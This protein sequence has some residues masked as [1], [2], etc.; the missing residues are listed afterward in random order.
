MS[1]LYRGVGVCLASIAPITAVQF[2]AN[3]KFL[4]LL[5]PKY[6]TNA[7]TSDAVKI[8]SA[9]IAGA[10]SS[11][12]SSPAELVMTL[13]QN[14]GKSFVN[15]IQDVVKQHGVTRLYRGLEMTMA[16][17]SVW[18]ASYLALGPVITQR[19]HRISP[20]VFG[21]DNDATISQKASASAVGSILAGI[22]TVVATQPLDTVKTVMQGEALNVKGNNATFALGTA[23]RMYCQA[24][25][26]IQPFFRGIVPRGIRLV[27][28]VFILGRSREWFEE[29]F[30]EKQ[31]LHF[32]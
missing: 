22:A 32:V 18:C 4:A 6:N 19:M 25:H 9:S 31:I 30:E 5:Q 8:T 12:I 24:G 7:S 26:S 16:R 17:E 15:T 21:S 11:L 10:F 23:K 29:H 13:Q 3:G 20:S 28:A 27:G 1:V 2:A 14:S